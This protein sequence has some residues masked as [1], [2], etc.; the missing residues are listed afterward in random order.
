MHL[1][2]LNIVK[3]FIFPIIY[4]KKYNFLLFYVHITQM[5]TKRFVVFVFSQSVICIQ[6]SE[7]NIYNEKEKKNQFIKLNAGNQLHYK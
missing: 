5:I 1:K 2:K 4:F 6:P 3:K 7:S